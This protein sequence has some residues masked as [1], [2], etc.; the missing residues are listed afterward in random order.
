MELMLAVQVS[1]VALVALVAYLAAGGGYRWF[2]VAIRTSPRDIKGLIRY[3]LFLF[4]VWKISRNNLSIGHIFRN[5]AAKHPRKIC[6]VF[7]DKEWTFAEM[8]EFSNKIANLFRSHGLRKGDTVGLMLENRPEY[9]GIWLGLSKIGVIT[10]LINFNLR[11][12]SLQ[13]SIS[14]AQCQALIFGEEFTDAIKE[15]MTTL[16]GV[17][18]YSFNPGQV[19][20]PRGDIGELQLNSLLKESSSSPA[21]I[22]VGF[23]D[24]MLYIYTS[25]TTG[26]PKAAVITHARYVF[27]AGAISY[28]LWFKSIDR[29][30][31]PLPLYHTAGGAMSVGQAIVYG[32]TVVIKKKFSASAYFED[33]AKYKCTVAQYIGEMCRYLLATS[34]KPADTQHSLRM[35]FGNGLRPQ[36]W[37]EF[38]ERFNIAQVGEFYGATEGNA[39]I[40]NIDSTV[41]AIGFVSRII[42]SVYPVSV[43]KVNQV[44][45]EPIRG[46]NGLCVLC[47]PDEP[48]VFIGKIIPS[49]P[50]RAYLGYVNEKESEKKIVTD[51]FSKGDSAFISGWCD[52]YEKR[53]FELVRLITLMRPNGDTL[54]PT[55]VYPIPLQNNLL[56][57][58]SCEC[59][60]RFKLARLLPGD[61]VVYDEFGY[62]FFK[63][64]TGDTFRW[65]GENVSTS[66][67]EGV[68]SNLV[69]FKDC[70]VYG[71][72][73]PG[74]EGRAGMAAIVDKELNINMS[75]LADG[76][77]KA[78]P[79][80][81]R[82]IFIR[83]IHQ[84]EMTGT[85]KMKKYDLQ[86][87]GFNPRKVLDQIFF[88]GTTGTY[89]LLTPEMYN[90]IVTGKIRL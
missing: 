81:A 3:L 45:G 26:L 21:D 77:K 89:D 40:V 4:S 29:F 90:Q 61:L 27:L 60:P 58:Y 36:I 7:E 76:L 34:P 55:N 49:N 44:T 6:F 35:V 8:E 73:V 66:E 79:A 57:D 83:I 33:I 17:R 30:Y 9:V 65:K 87:D 46:P 70:V 78:L 11:Q 38:V 15:I 85:Y 12:N 41:G 62:I 80:Y 14:V 23:L 42:P 16:G 31:T 24:K 53:L 19:R 51:V 2:Y 28:L 39:N 5:N 71:V 82:P 1:L 10:A 47:K 56:E 64:R 69:D 86:K 43:I 67:V 13:H 88:L 54:L 50:A 84:L 68:V 75:K 32:S 18:L 37:T 48:G 22:D 74:A 20:H 72:E 52:P 63:D 59:H 25:G